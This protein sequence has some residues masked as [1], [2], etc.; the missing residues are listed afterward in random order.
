MLSD[1][2]M[3]ESDDT[4]TDLPAEGKEDPNAALAELLADVINGNIEA[5]AEEAL[6]DQST[7]TSE[8]TPDNDYEEE[9]EEVEELD[10]SGESMQV[11]KSQLI[12]CLAQFPWHFLY[13][14]YTKYGGSVLYNFALA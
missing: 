7:M 10:Y 12:E 3:T 13:Y 9:Y 4:T 1:V 14:F 11:T 5:A 2:T 8:P 6:P